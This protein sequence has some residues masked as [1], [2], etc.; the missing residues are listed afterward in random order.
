MALGRL[1]AAMMVRRP[2]KSAEAAAACQSCMVGTAGSSSGSRGK[3]LQRVLHKPP[4]LSE[5]YLLVNAAVKAMQAAD[6][7]AAMLAAAAVVRPSRSA[8]SKK[9]G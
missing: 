1:V 3:C 7:T 9:A 6:V 4:D 8:G 2:R 5:K